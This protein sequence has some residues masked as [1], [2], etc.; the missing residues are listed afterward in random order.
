M[1][2]VRDAKTLN[3]KAI[4]SMRIAMETFNSYSDDGRVTSVL[5]HLQHAVE[6]VM[7]AVLCQNKVKLFDKDSGR[8]IGFERCLGLCQANFGLT[9]LEAG[10][11]RVVDA[12]R[13]DAQHWFVYIPE[14]ILYMHTRAL[15]TVFDA[16]LTR[17]LDL[18]LNSFIPARVLPV[19]TMPPGDF[20][21][22]VDREF[23]LVGELLRP[24]N[25]R[26]DE[27]RARIRTL[28]AMEALVT[29]EVAISEKDINRIERAIKTGSE[30]SSVFPRLNTINTTV[31]GAGATLKV[32]FTKKEGAPV[33]FI[34]GDEPEGAAAVREIDLQKK[35][36]MN[37]SQL[38]Q[39]LG[40]TE[41][42]SVALRRCLGIDDD[43][44]CMHVF[45]FGKVKINRFSDNALRSMKDA[46][47]DG[48]DLKKVWIDF[49]PG[50]RKGV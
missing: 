15:I 4:S 1:P 19:S 39:K 26:R 47:K 30:L 8:S 40:L 16:Y 9:A 50:A 45:K 32:H 37:A 35:F 24:G 42:K 12:L 13:D 5:L 49:R 36:H 34:A 23:K 18:D 17:S 10:V 14:D 43:P 3:A 11:F 31:D 46:I 41:P 48:I 28:L 2:L 38:A 22:L 25:R 27:A 20:E 6:M 7:K 21:F 29:E 44:G 33:K